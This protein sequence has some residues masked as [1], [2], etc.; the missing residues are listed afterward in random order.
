M[1]TSAIYE[2]IHR[3]PSQIGLASAY[4]GDAAR[5]HV[6]RNLFPVPPSTRGSRYAT[7]TGKG[8]RPRRIDL[9]PWRYLTAAIFIVYFLFIVALP[10]L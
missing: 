1:F 6:S 9:G 8:F 5:H 3:Y 10:F 4:G 7:M 2:A